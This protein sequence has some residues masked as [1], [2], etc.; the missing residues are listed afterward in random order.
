MTKPLKPVPQFVQGKRETDKDFMRRVEVETH[1]VVMTAKMEDKYK[2]N[3]VCF[4]FLISTL[5]KKSEQKISEN[6]FLSVVFAFREKKEIFLKY[7]ITLIKEWLIAVS[8]KF[9]YVFSCEAMNKI[10]IIK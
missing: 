1:R 8:V 4:C 9:M 2:V 3:V 10:F 5:L 7:V 6:I